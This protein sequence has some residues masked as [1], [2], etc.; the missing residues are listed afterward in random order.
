[1]IGRVL[2]AVA[3]ASGVAGAVSDQGR[4]AFVATEGT[5]QDIWIMDADGTD[6]TRLTDE[7][8]FDIDPSFS[9]D[10][11]QIVFVSDRSGGTV[12]DLFVMDADGTNV[13]QLT[14]AASAEFQSAAAFDPAWSPD[15]KR[16]AFSANFSGYWDIWTIGVDGRHLRN[17][18]RSEATDSSPAWSPDGRSIAFVSDEDAGESDLYVM[19]AHGGRVRRLTFT[20][21]VYDAEPAWSPD[22]ATIAFASV[23]ETGALDI[24]TIPVQGGEPTRLTSEPATDFSP[25]W[26]PDGSSIAFSRNGQVWV[27]N[28]DGTGAILLGSGFADD[29]APSWR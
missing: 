3:L 5:N 25:A 28:A 11:T 27:M 24:F 14:D 21:I 18:T 26:S 19:N 8:G 23:S 20:P 7:T 15:G 10:G 22:G 16:I 1:M 9:P 17:L 6:V 2:V 29:A 13:R 4:I 12:F